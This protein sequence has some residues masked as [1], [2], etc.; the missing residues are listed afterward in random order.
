MIINE[1]SSDI[2]YT[3][4]YWIIIFLI[5]TLERDINKNL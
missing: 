3:S 1:L 5:N 4:D 2:S